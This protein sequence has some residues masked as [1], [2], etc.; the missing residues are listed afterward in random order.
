MPANSRWDLIRGLK[1]S[2]GTPILTLWSENPTRR[3]YTSARARTHKSQRI[4]CSDYLR[5][6]CESS[7]VLSPDRRGFLIY[8]LCQLLME[9]ILEGRWMKYEYEVLVKWYFQRR[10]TKV[11][12]GG[13]EEISLERFVFRWRAG[14]D[15]S[16]STA[17]LNFWTE[18]AAANFAGATW[19]STAKWP[20]T[21]PSGGLLHGR[22]W[23][24]NFHNNLY[25]S[26][27]FINNR[28]SSKRRRHF[29]H[30]PVCAHYNFILNC[31]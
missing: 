26:E 15:S 16:R 30:L 21:G 8:R 10:R 25:P 6:T 5:W 14:I 31:L 1:G 3:T 27:W 22:E 13:T 20:T 24:F 28:M 7:T 17:E 12:R 11:L 4:T 9:Y 2:I 29:Y 19:C 18:I 23:A